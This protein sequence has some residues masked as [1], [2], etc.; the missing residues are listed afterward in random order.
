MFFFFN[1]EECMY[2]FLSMYLWQ[3]KSMHT[4]FM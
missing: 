4:I 1:L 3:E 2:V